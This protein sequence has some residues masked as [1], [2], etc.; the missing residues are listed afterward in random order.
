MSLRGLALGFVG[1]LLFLIANFAILASVSDEGYLN[2]RTV[3]AAAGIWVLVFSLYTFVKLKKRP[4][5]SLPEGESYCQ[6]S[7][8]VSI[9]TAKS[10]GTLT[11][12]QM[13]LIVFFVFSDGMGTITGSA[14]IFAQEELRMNSPEVVLS[15]ILASLTSVFSCFLFKFIHDKI[16]FAA[17][18]ILIIKLVLMALLPVYSM[19]FLTTKFEYFGAI[20]VFGMNNGSQPAFT[21]SIYANII[22]QGR[23][24]EYFSFYELFDKGSAWLGPL[25]VGIISQATGSIRNAF[26]AIVVFSIIGI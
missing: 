6:H 23:E 10:L 26:S 22:P 14:L 15:L 9:R 1:Q 20:A 3:I 13:F 21:R 18:N 11:E 5:P 7:A 4:G 24:A 19:V 2:S 25:M 8:K 16:P 17:K 12:I